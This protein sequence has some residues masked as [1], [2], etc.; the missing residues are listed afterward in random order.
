MKNLT[1]VIALLT[2]L[3]TSCENEYEALPS[4]IFATGELEGIFIDVKLIPLLG[5]NKAQISFDVNFDVLSQEQR[6]RIIGFYVD[7]NGT[8][9]TFDIEQ[10]SFAFPVP[11]GQTCASLGLTSGAVFSDACVTICRNF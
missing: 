9:R 5:Q 4:N 3:M 1:L 7:Y 2:L 6:D 10:Q 8:P 11:S